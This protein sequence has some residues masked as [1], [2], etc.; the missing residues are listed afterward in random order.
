MAASAFW[1]T[2]SPGLGLGPARGL[3]D[4]RACCSVWAAWTASAAAA[5]LDLQSSKR[6]TAAAAAAGLR[7]AA[8][9]ADWRAYACARACSPSRPNWLL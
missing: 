5:L 3:A 6:F 7:A 8:R 1:P 9:A 2:Y 4:R